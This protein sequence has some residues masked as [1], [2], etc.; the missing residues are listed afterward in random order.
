MSTQATVNAPAAAYP[1]YAPVYF[2]APTAGNTG[3]FMCVS[4]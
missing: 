4:V 1:Y 3:V 2:V